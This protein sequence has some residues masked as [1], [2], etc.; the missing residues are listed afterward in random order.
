MNRTLEQAARGRAIEAR[1]GQ[2]VLAMVQVAA[3]GAVLGL[4]IGAATAWMMTNVA[5]RQLAVAWL[6][7]LKPAMVFQVQQQAGF[8]ADI[9]SPE[10]VAAMM[11][12]T[13]MA[14]AGIIVALP[15]AIGLTMLLRRQWIATARDAALDQVLRG[16]ELATPQQLASLLA[17]ITKH[18][19]P[20]VFGGVPVPPED[21]ARH[22]LLVGQSGSGKT[23]ALRSLL[24]QIVQRGEHALIFDADGS[25]VAQF[26]SPARGDVILNPFDARTA[27]WNPLTDIATLADAHRVATVLLP[28][29][30]KASEAA[31]WYDQA[32]TLIAHILDHLAASGGT[33]NDLAA[34]LNVASPDALRII[35]A[36]TPA[37]RIFEA[38]GERATASVLFM[39]GIAARTVALLAAIPDTAPAFSF[40][41]FYADLAKHEGR[42]PLVFLAAPRRYREAA[43]PVIAAWID[44]AA[45]AILQRPPGD[46]PKAWLIFDELPSLPA[47]QSLLVLLPEGRKH[48]ACVVIAFQ[49]IAQM[50]E[51]YGQ[52]G[53]EI[54]TGQTASQV[55]M[56]VGDHTTAKWAT[57]L[58]GMIEVE[59]QRASDQLGD[60]RQAHGSLATTRERK[61]LLLDIDLTGLRVGEA[62]L[63]LSGYPIAQ[64][65]IDPGAPLPTIAPAFVPAPLPPRVIPDRA[66]SP[67]PTR[68]EDR[69]DW[70]DLGGPF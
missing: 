61:T 46:A 18:Q 44:A 63:R 13:R 17:F 21:E 54:I 56:S 69:P 58:S 66:D 42:K 59:N 29:P 48:A 2:A 10:H 49:S 53:A 30:S 40:D 6:R 34:M 43:A 16:N 8:G 4:A 26:Y 12:L 3:L 28:K 57:D 65:T 7:Q 5:D 60:D 62:F 51:R 24:R 41:R 38:G 23:T 55:I 19:C 45:S 35:V 11:M 47:V 67:P 20:I 50:Q 33:L 36:G 25:Y 70:L 22:L 64:V 14:V 9:P 15:L 31:V 1:R 68:A 27:R 39:M 37:M 52:E 32:R